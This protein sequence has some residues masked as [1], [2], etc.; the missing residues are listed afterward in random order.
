[1]NQKYKIL[2]FL[3]FDKGRDIEILMPVVYYAE[4]YLNA[5]VKFA[6]I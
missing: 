3:D 4:K 6:F 5:D 2:C 1:M